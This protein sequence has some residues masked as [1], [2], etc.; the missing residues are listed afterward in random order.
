MYSGSS[1]RLRR[2]GS[3][4]AVGPRAWAFAS[5]A[6]FG[7][8]APPTLLAQSLP[9]L[10]LERLYEAPPLSGTLPTGLAWHPDGRRLTFLRGPADSPQ[11]CGF[12][13][14]DGEETVLLD[15]SRL[16]V[17]GDDAR[18][19]PLAAASWLADGKH[20]LVP[21]DGDIFVVDV[22]KAAVR[23]L[24]RTAQDEQFATASPDGRRVAFVRESDLYTVE[25]ASGRETRLTHS[26]SETL[27]NGRLDWVYQEELAPR[28]AQA[29]VWAPNSRAI[30]YLQLDQTRVARFPIVDF[31][32]VPNQVSWQRYPAP[33]SPNAI[34][35][36]GIAVLG[37]HGELAS[38]RL[39][40]MPPED[41]YLLPQLGWTGDS[42]SV[43]AQA[44]NRAQ[45]QLE[46]RL[47][48]ATA[49]ER[50]PSAGR[51]VLTERSTT[52]LD[53]FGAPLFLGDGHRFLWVS[54]RDGFAHIYVCETRG[55]CRAVTQGPWAVE[56]RISFA[57]PETPFVFDQHSGFLY[58]TATEKDP[59]E[60]HLYRVRLDGTG[61]TRLTREDGV[62]QVLVSPDG[63]F[64][65][66]TWSNT[67]TPPK[68][69]VSSQDGTRRWAIEDNTHPPIL[70]FERGHIEPVA[71]SAQDGTRLYAALLK[72]A[73]FDPA[74]RYP[75]V[76]DVYG[77]PHVQVVRNSWGQASAFDHLLAS[78][79]FLVFWLD[80]RG[81][82]GRGTAFEAPI[83][84]QL[85]RIE[86][87]DQLAG[88]AYLRS[89]PFVDPA[90]IG[91]AGWSYGGYLTLYAAT[92]AP[93]AFRSAVAGAPVTDWRLYDSIY[94][95]RYLGTPEQNP[96]GY[97]AS[98]P[99]RNV[100]KLK[101]ELL[102]LHG[103]ADDNV[104]LANTVAFVAA[105]VGAGKPYSLVLLPGQSHGVS[106]KQERAAR[107]RAILAHLERTLAPRD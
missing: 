51:I 78:H 65:A 90:R 76:I 38:E 79:G 26:G 37:K 64:Y 17:P 67:E 58:F 8:S 99:I 57:T 40:S 18:G 61:R 63:R 25:I 52:W 107:G 85:G 96:A 3:A 101:A 68:L 50:E 60:R 98:S 22:A 43:A 73:D 33:G 93:E 4:S 83:R 102:L 24:V 88:V 103:T 47:V 10:T 12:D 86:L 59:R 34:A 28:A 91:I 13:V 82:A 81:S 32:A 35:R 84:R 75:V 89:L 36:L 19:L 44:L 16:H 87:E 71:L 54:E 72:P 21:A 94:T 9:K 97:D 48:S 56:A 100:A 106:G 66:D 6:L 23:A 27:L 55:G 53:T 77:G 70:D 95:E 104:H 105:L 29:F 74:R 31:L 46:L 1:S 62:H 14:A 2:A 42:R 15:G 20:L 69:V 5:L 30:A 7:L 41:E 49:E 45:N 80:N 39:V 11:L 92:N